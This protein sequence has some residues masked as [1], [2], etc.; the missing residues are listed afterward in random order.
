MSTTGRRELC[1]EGLALFQDLGASDEMAMPLF[2]LG[3]AALLQGR[4][5]EALARLRTG[6]ELTRDLDYAGQSVYFLEGLAAVFAAGEQAERA[7]RLLGAAE[8]AGERTGVSLE[9]GVQEIHNRTVEAATAALGRDGFALAHAVGRALELQQ[10]IDYALET[11]GEPT[12]VT[13]ASPP[14]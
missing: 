3:V 6:L 4:H 1:E 9:P 14:D 7:G 2:N 12:E 13:T 8:A 10:A 11:A 5:A